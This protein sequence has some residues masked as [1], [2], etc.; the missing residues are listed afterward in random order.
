MHA[1]TTN[2]AEFDKGNYRKQA[3]G[4]RTKAGKRNIPT[5]MYINVNMEQRLAEKKE[6]YKSDENQH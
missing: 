4:I 5:Q 1:E 2:E 3:K 6:A